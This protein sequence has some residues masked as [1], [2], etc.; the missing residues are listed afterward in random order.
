MT[1]AD[2]RLCDR[3]CQDHGF[4]P[5]MLFTAAFGILLASVSRQDDVCAGTPVSVRGSRELKD[6]AGMVCQYSSDKDPGRGRAYLSGI[7]GAD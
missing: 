6:M 5:F 3:F 2:S 4:T 7:Y 1:E